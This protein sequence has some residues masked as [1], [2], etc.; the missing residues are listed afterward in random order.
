MF[1]LI[2]LLV[3]GLIIGWIAQIIHP[4]EEKGGLAMT[5][6]TGVVGSFIGGIINWVLWG[7]GYSPAGFTMSI[8]GG[9]IFCWIYLKWSD[10]S[11]VS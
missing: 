9:V 11:K 6:L 8:V 2:Y 7:G 5:I 4:G 3:S 10:S 1:Y